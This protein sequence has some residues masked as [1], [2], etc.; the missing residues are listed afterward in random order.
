MVDKTLSSKGFFE[1]F[2]LNYNKLTGKYTNDSTRKLTHAFC[3]KA[4]LRQQKAS[5]NM[6]PGSLIEICLKL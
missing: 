5:Q 3:M 1:L 2:S 4:L 6:L